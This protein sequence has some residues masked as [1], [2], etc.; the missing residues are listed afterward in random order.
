MSTKEVKIGETYNVRV[1]VEH[2][3]E[4]GWFKVRTSEKAISFI[5]S[6]K[7]QD[8]F[9][10]LPQY[11][12]CRPF[13]KGDRVAPKFWNG[14]PPVASEERANSEFLPENKIY[15]V[16]ADERNSIAFID[17]HGKRAFIPVNHLEL[18]TPVE[19]LGPYSIFNNERLAAWTL[20][21]NGLIFEYYPYRVN[22][23]DNIARSKEEAQAA[24]EAKRDRLN[25]KH[26]KE[27]K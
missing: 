3:D 23:S 21:K 20:Q 13:K 1:K 26:R 25:A 8:A 24:A 22:E 6:P 19:E 11:D 4:D 2:I 17:Y 7:E 9:S 27:Q 12:P 15:T 14:R 10:P 18:V 5:L 16:L